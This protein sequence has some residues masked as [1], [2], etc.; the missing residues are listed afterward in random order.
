MVQREL[1]KTRGELR[2]YG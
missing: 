1:W 2:C